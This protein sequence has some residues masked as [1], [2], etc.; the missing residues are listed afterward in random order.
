MENGV[1]IYVINFILTIGVEMVEFFYKRS[2]TWRIPMQR[3]WLFIISIGILSGLILG[4]CG[5]SPTQI[6]TSALQVM[7]ETDTAALAEPNTPPTETAPSSAPETQ[8]AA[9]IELPAEKPA[10]RGGLRASPPSQVAL[11]SGQLQLVEFFAFW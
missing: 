9:P 7:Q 8:E 3:R 6:A 2:I 1:N 5:S 4:A 11:A 10:G